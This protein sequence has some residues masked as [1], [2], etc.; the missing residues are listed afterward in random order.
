MGKKGGKKGKKVKKEKEGKK[1]NKMTFTEALLAFQIQVKETEIDRYL[2]EVKHVEEKNKRYKERNER[3]KAEQLIH[4]RDLLHEA[5]NQDKEFAKKEVFNR[6]QVDQAIREKWEYIRTMERIFE[7]VHSRINQLAEDT[8]KKE[9]ERDYWLAYKNVGSKE[10]GKQIQLLE[11]ELVNIQ[12]NFKDIEEHFRQSLENTKNKINLLVMK[13]MEEKKELAT[14]NAIKHIDK[15]SRKE[16]KENSWLKDEVTSYRKE[17]NDLEIEVQN[18]E[19]ENLKL[20]SELFDCRLQDLKISRSCFLTQ[21]AGLEVPADSLLGQ[22]FATLEWMEESGAKG[23]RPKSAT[24]LAVEKKVSAAEEK[25]KESHT[26][27]EMCTW[28]PPT[29]YCLTQE[30]TDLLYGEEKDFQVKN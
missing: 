28:N 10:H 14:E 8:A 9:F 21:V 23:P 7:E 20:I 24:L 15:F 26:E 29:D 3:L 17:V 4:I 19:Q 5:K 25:L 18:L 1:E 27:Q 12:Q 16:I 22:D 2:V 13:Q 6:D 30:L 11:M